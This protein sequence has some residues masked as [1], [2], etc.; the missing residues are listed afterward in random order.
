MC[1]PMPDNALDLLNRAREAREG[2]DR[3]RAVGPVLAALVDQGISYELI[4]SMTGIASATAHRL[5]TR[6]AP[7]SGSTSSAGAS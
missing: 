1:E 3:W 5:V 6:C 7:T 2:R 4:E